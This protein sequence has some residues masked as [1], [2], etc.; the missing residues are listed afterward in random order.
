MQDK[1]VY[2]NMCFLTLAGSKTNS[3]SANHWGKWM[4]LIIIISKWICQFS[5]N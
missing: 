4:V 3:S 5:A 2:V 1:F